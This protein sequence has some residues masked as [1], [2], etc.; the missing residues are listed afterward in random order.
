[1]LL[2]SSHAA[3]PPTIRAASSM[4]KIRLFIPSPPLGSALLGGEAGL[5]GLSALCLL[6]DEG[7]E[8]LNAGIPDIPRLDG[9][10]R[11]EYPEYAP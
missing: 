2:S 8:T 5:I 10:E 9:T 4:L 7:G 6:D 11:C 3:M 1:M